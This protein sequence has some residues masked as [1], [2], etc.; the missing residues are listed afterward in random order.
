MTLICSY[1]AAVRHALLRRFARPWIDPG[2]SAILLSFIGNSANA[3]C[4]QRLLLLVQRRCTAC[5]TN[6]VLQ[7]V[8]NSQIIFVSVK[9]PYVLQVLREVSSSLSSAHVVV[10]IA[11]G[12]P[13]SQMQVRALRT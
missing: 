13:L 5:L 2:F 8:E 7:V 3:Q 6:L 12:I 4:S 9:P 1:E 11:A 10:S